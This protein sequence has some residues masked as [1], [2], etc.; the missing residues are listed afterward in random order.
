MPV[1]GCFEEASEEGS[2]GGADVH[3]ALWVPLDGEDIVVWVG[4]F[5]SF[6]DGVLVA[7]GG[8]GEALAGAIDGL[9]V[10]G[11]YREPEEVLGEVSF[12]GVGLVG[13][14]AEE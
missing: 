11:V 2:G 1:G 6:D 12:G 14:L 13:D 7:A 5:H 9:V 8:D 4:A 10:A 3:A